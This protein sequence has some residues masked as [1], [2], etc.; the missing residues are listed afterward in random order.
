MSELHI[1][2]TGFHP[3][4]VSLPP[5]LTAEPGDAVVAAFH[6]GHDIGQ[7]LAEEQLPPP[8]PGDIPAPRHHDV[9][10]LRFV[11][12][13]DT[14]RIDD[15][16][17]LAR[18]LKTRFLDFLWS[19]G[20]RYVKV[21]DVQYSFSRDRLFILISTVDP[22]NLQ[23]ETSEFQKQV[24]GV[25]D[26]RRITSR[27]AAIF[28]GGCGDCGR[29]FCCKQLCGANS[30]ATIRMAR[31]QNLAA[32]GSNLHGVCGKLRC[33]LRHEYEHY[34]RMAQ[35]LPERGAQVTTPDGQ[36]GRVKDVNLL[37]GRVTVNLGGGKTADYAADELQRTAPQTPDAPGQA[38]ADMD[39]ADVEPMPDGR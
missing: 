29:P 6:D 22:M 1:R 4:P 21:L 14:I 32:A 33:C 17:R 24:K 37:L 13:N 36:K 35:I 30:N 16:A 12:K 23:R 19:Q 34:H 5:E 31:V 2:F 28:I 18:Q 26:V 7:L 9:R 10:I 38:G 3:F 20:V 11:T 25:L 8:H 39:S 15:N 27:D